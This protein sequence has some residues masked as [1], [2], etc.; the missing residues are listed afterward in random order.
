MSTTTWIYRTIARAVLCAA[1]L[2][3]AAPA[4]AICTSAT[5]NSEM[6]RRVVGLTQDGISALLG[7]TPTALA[8]APGVPQAPQIY[9]WGLVDGALRKQIAVQFNQTGVAASARYQEIP[10]V[11][12]RSARDDN[13]NAQVA[14]AVA[15]MAAASGAAR[16][17]ASG[18]TIC[19]PATINPGAVQTIRPYMS[20]AAV[21]GVLGCAPT[22]IPPT[23]IGVWIWGIPF[24]ELAGAKTQMGVVFDE[25]G[26]VF[27]E[28]QVFPA[29]LKPRGNGAL[30]VEPPLPPYGNWV[31][32]VVP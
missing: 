14:V 5:I 32:G 6:S 19:T 13:S 26:A 11:P 21:S 17:A 29:A 4:G 8:P 24:S 20:P 31:P 16:S 27:A 10:L 22:E 1:A 15:L 9:T 23:G 12:G 7:C 2:A 30:R 3:A 18:G 28:Y 25:A